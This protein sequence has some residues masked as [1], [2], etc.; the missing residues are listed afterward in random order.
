MI[1]NMYLLCP[2]L[3]S[4]SFSVFLTGIQQEISLMS[5]SNTFG[6]KYPFSFQFAPK[7]LHS[8]KISQAQKLQ[9]SQN[10]IK[11][12]FYRSTITDGDEWPNKRRHHPFFFLQISTIAFSIH[13]NNK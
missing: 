13:I 8:N 1:L 4:D 7:I 12:T 10:M 9:N 5:F 6:E 3:F 2:S 11:Q